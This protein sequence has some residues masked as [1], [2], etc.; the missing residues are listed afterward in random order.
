MAVLSALFATVLLMGLGVSIVLLG[1]TEAA[2]ATHDRTARMLREASL[3]VVHL[4]VADLRAQPSWSAVLAEGTLP[5]SAAPGRLTDPTLSPQAPWGGPLLDLRQVTAEV[6]AAAD[7]G[8]GDPQVWRLY[9]YGSLAQVAG[10]DAASPCY[11]AAWVADDPADG[12]GDPSAD[13]NGILAVRAVAL[14][15]GN[16]RAT[17]AVSIARTSVPGGPEL[18]RLLTIRPQP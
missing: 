14:G 8:V 4:A 18:V 6:Q 15:P 1:T 13:S 16:A 5:V 9:E 10:L 11:I 7:I 3:G 12:D 17:T 2:L